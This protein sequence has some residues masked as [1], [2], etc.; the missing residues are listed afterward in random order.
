MRPHPQSSAP[1]SIGMLTFS[2]GRGPEEMLIPGAV[3]PA[4]IVPRTSK[5]GASGV[6]P[7][8]ARWRPYPRPI[9]VEVLAAPSAAG[10]GGEDATALMACGT[11]PVGVSSGR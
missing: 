11:W 7:I 5:V 8:D 2:T 6:P 3:P 9:P 4:V 1:V 10:A